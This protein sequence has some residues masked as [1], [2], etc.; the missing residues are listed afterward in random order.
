MIVNNGKHSLSCFQADT[1]EVYTSQSLKG[2]TS[3]FSVDPPDAQILSLIGLPQGLL[4]GTPYQCRVLTCLF[5][6][7]HITGDK[8]LLPAQ[9][10]P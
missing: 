10:P 7:F 3:H 4:R 5:L 8:A 2:V 6:P 9:D 1:A